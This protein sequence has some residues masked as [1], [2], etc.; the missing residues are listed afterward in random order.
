VGKLVFKNT[1]EET[2]ND[3]KKRFK[4]WFDETIGK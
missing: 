1:A 4:K 3:Q 2:L